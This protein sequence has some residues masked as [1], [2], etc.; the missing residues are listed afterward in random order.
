MIVNQI[1]PH[2]ILSMDS[3][4][5]KG[6]RA[7]RTCPKDTGITAG[8]PSNPDKSK[9]YIDM[10][11]CPTMDLRSTGA[12]PDLEPTLELCLILDCTSSMGPWIEK[13]KRTLNEIIDKTI[14]E[15]EDDGEL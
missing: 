5:N 10:L 15:C 12:D 3:F 14:K 7:T 4:E 13:A 11:K 2:S 8:G 1:K 9:V 6:T